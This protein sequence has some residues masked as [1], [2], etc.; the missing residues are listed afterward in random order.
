M[1]T[2]TIIELDARDVFRIFASHE[3][4]GAALVMIARGISP[5]EPSPHRH[6]G[7]DP[8]RWRT[9]EPDVRKALAAMLESG[10][11]RE[12]AIREPIPSALRDEVL[13]RDCAACVYCGSADQLHIDHVLPVVRGGRSERENLCVAC[14][15]CNL[16]KG[17]KTLA[18]W[19]G[20]A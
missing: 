19:S 8:R 11:I 10:G 12:R 4:I 17:A 6:L 3:A 18:E 15:P 7:I 5:D 14:A 20:R 16:S 2:R 9:I 1:N 13:E